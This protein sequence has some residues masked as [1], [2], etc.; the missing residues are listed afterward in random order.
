MVSG[1]APAL[2]ACLLFA[3][4]LAF[5]LITAATGV[6]EGDSAELAAAAHFLS[7]AH[8]PGYPLYLLLGHLFARLPVGDVAWRLNVMSA[9]FGAS[10]VALLFLFLWRLLRALVP[11]LLAAVAF[12]LAFTF[13]QQATV[14]EVYTLNIFLL[15]VLLHLALGWEQAPPPARRSF[16]LLF[17]LT[18]GLALGDHTNPVLFLPAFAWLA[19]TGGWRPHRDGGTVFWMLLLF[20]A[21]LSLYLYLPIRSLENPPVINWV[22]TDTFDKVVTVVTAKQFRTQ[23]FAFGPAT[24]LLNLGKG[25]AFL[26]A[27]FPVVGFFLGL[28]GIRAAWHEDRRRALF[29]LLAG[30]PV[31]LAAINYDIYD[32]HVYYLPFYLCF[33]VFLGYGL[34]YVGRAGGAAR[35]WLLVALLFLPYY[36]VYSLLGVSGN[37]AG[38]YLWIDLAKSM[39]SLP[40]R[41][42]VIC[43][44]PH[45]SVLRYAQLIENLRP[46]ILLVENS[47]FKDERYLDDVRRYRGR[48]EVYLTQENALVATRSNLEPEGLYYRVAPRVP[49]APV[50]P[51]AGLDWQ[52]AGNGLFLALGECGPAIPRELFSVELFWKKTAV[53]DAGDTQPEYR[54]NVVSADGRTATWHKLLPVQAGFPVGEWAPGAVYAQRR[55]IYLPARI[56]ERF[57]L[58]LA[59]RKGENGIQLREFTITP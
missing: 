41:A 37:R 7:F 25:F 38:N 13:W 59:D 20:L 35:Q 53:A 9:I 43:W 11:A 52:E 58:Q 15:L 39:E 27:Q 6:H 2:T 23:M 26:V 46:D 18:F 54:L 45:F 49:P 4:A 57:T 42:T 33:A 32:V 1:P 12:A 16:L 51:P 14:A 3:A 30:A 22:K 40:P 44:W 10:G 19:W 31:I 5:Y 36:P 48:G 29:L 56:P 24:L 21:G 47:S 34:R 50:T 17:A 8:A 55:F 28:I